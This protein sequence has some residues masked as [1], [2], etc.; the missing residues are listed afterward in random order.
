MLLCM[1]QLWSPSN[2]SLV[3]VAHLVLMRAH[4]L[5]VVVPTLWNRLLKEVKEAQSVKAFRTLCK[6]ALLTRGFI[7]IQVAGILL[8]IIK[9]YL[10]LLLHHVLI[11]YCKQ[12]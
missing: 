5:S 12:P 1:P 8:C 2:C 4:G 6:A 11:M 10:V 7:G 9:L 3:K